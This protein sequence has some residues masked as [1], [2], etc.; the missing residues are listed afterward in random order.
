MVNPPR[1]GLTAPVRDAVAALL[2]TTLIY[3]S[4][5]PTSLA[6]DLADLKE[7]GYEALSVT[8]FDLMPGTGQ[9]ETVVALRRIS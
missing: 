6:R 8:P 4:C 3:V 5:S 1:K 7:R 2:P 9:V